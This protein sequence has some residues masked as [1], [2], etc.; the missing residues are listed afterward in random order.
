MKNTFL[1]K[2]GAVAL[3]A[4]MAVTFAPVASLNVFAANTGIQTLDNVANT[5]TTTAIIEENGSYV[6][7][8]GGIGTGKTVTVSPSATDV[9]IDVRGEDDIKI[10]IEGNKT[11]NVTV[12]SSTYHTDGNA[13]LPHIP[14]VTVQGVTSASSLAFEGNLVVS[15]DAI[16]VQDYLGTNPA[17]DTDAAKPYRVTIGDVAI[18]TA[19]A[20]GTNDLYAVNGAVNV[21]GLKKGHQAILSST[22]NVGTTLDATAADDTSLTKVVTKYDYRFYSESLSSYGT[23]S[24]TDVRFAAGSGY[25]KNALDGQTLPDKKYEGRAISGASIN[26]KYLSSNATKKGLDI[27]KITYDRAITLTQADKDKWVKSSIKLPYTDGQGE[28]EYKRG[29]T[30]FHDA[31]ITYFT[32]DP[33]AYVSDETGVAVI[34][35]SKYVISAPDPDGKTDAL[36][37]KGVGDELYNVSSFAGKSLAV[38]RGTSKD[39]TAVNAWNLL[40]TK[41]GVKVTA[42]TSSSIA[43]GHT[44]TIGTKSNDT[45]NKGIIFGANH[46]EGAAQVVFGS[47]EDANDNT[48]VTTA[49]EVPQV[50]DG[51]YAIV[52]NGYTDTKV[53]LGTGVTYFYHQKAAQ[54]SSEHCDYVFGSVKDATNALNA[55][56]IGKNLNTTNYFTQAKP[57]ENVFVAKDI[58][59]TVKGVTAK[60]NVKGEISADGAKAA[61]GTYTWIINQGY[62][63]DAVPAYRMYRKSGEHVYTI[64]PA[65]VSMLEQA[66][67]INEGVGF[68]VNSVASKKG[69]PIYRVYNVNGGGMHFYTASAAEK[70]MLLANG[71]TEGKVVFYGADKATG[72]PVYRTYNTGSNNG[73]HNYTT[74]IAESDMNVKAGW[75]AEGV[76]FYVFK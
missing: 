74:N 57:G 65:E 61:D 28:E 45:S 21:K 7:S 70:D 63:T 16:E 32:T 62:G 68:K 43:L 19:A 6:V 67:W 72:I 64:N 11:A 52:N 25:W 56:L 20:T 40:Q 27:V 22:A 69:T 4:V 29:T 37:D 54:I 39:R 66:G 50:A 12:A 3:A 47:A 38:L 75:R 8:A 42:P 30:S 23:S 51:V 59:T 10:I 18:G 49:L 9:K 24:Y 34:D 15:G 58:K 2:A 14:E 13:K 73:E 1:K 36:D 55:V 44:T 26:T 17:V 35:G 46:V 31:G 5:I 76:A 33:T 71:W 60:V 41:E 48:T 53:T